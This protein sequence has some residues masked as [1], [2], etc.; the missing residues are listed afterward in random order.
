[1]TSGLQAGDLIIVAGRPSMGKTTIAMNM[2][3][4]V[5]VGSGLPVAEYD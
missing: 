4:N 5:A 1:M 3:E 2:A